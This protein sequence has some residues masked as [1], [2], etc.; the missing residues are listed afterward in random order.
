MSADRTYPVAVFL[1]KTVD[2]VIYAVLTAGAASLVGLTVGAFFAEPLVVLKHLLFVGGFLQVGVGVAQLWPTDSSD[3][4]E[5]DPDAATRTQR[6][7]DRLSLTRRLG[8]PA[9]RH[10][11]LGTKRSL[12][13]LA[14]L[15][16]SFGL[17]AA[18]GV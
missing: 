1:S 13:G 12:S 18:F 15:L 14:I 11:A 4:R 2:G 7:V 8:L 17:E 10:F 9:G 3:V 5:P 6:V 16:V